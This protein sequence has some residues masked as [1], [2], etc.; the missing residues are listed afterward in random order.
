MWRT[1]NKHTEQY[2]YC[3]CIWYG[4]LEN[5]MCTW[6]MKSV[7][8]LQTHNVY[9]IYIKR[10]EQWKRKTQTHIFFTIAAYIHTYIHSYNIQLQTKGVRSQSFRPLKMLQNISAPYIQIQC[11]HY[12]CKHFHLLPLHIESIMAFLKNSIHFHRS[13]QKNEWAEHMIYML[14]SY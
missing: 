6:I 8:K 11:I 5:W 3:W 1:Q 14:N 4:L 10:D 9:C 2:T 13:N 7:D 12:A